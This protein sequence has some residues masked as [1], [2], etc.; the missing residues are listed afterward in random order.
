MTLTPSHLSHLRLAWQ[1]RTLAYAVDASATAKCLGSVGRGERLMGL[2][3]SLE[4]F[5]RRTRP[6]GCIARQPEDPGAWQ[7]QKLM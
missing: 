5:V 6:Q 4:N 3:F 2:P 1:S 7:E